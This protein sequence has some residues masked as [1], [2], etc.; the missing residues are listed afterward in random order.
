MTLKFGTWDD[1]PWPLRNIFKK[2]ECNPMNMR[3][4]TVLKHYKQLA[5]ED[6]SLAGP[7]LQAMAANRH[8]SP[9]QMHKVVYWD[10][11]TQGHIHPQVTLPAV[12]EGWYALSAADQGEVL[13]CIN[14]AP[15]LPSVPLPSVA[16]TSEP[17]PVDGDDPRPGPGQE[18]GP[19]IPI[20]ARSAVEGVDPADVYNGR[21]LTT[22]T[23]DELREVAAELGLTGVSTLNKEDLFASIKQRRAE[24]EVDRG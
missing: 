4:S 6:S 22:M 12:L 16:D 11:R 19:P 20:T 7:C 14:D 10:Q 2:E 9:D 8:A 1:K 18:G 5:T 15:D 24:N 13:D 17:L 21:D 23:K 3:V